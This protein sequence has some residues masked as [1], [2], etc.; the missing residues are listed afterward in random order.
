MRLQTRLVVAFPLFLAAAV[1][2]SSGNSNFPAKVSG[3]I[4]Y[5]G[6]P[7]TAGMVTFHSKNNEV[8]SSSLAPDGTYTMANLPVGEMT[9]CV[10]TESFN[11]NK[12]TPEYKGGK[13]PGQSGA[14]SVAPKK[15]STSSPVPSGAGQGGGSY[16]K[17]PAKYA[18]RSGSPLRAT[19]EKGN[20]TKDFE[21]TD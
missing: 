2:C 19:L 1:G 20:N 10:E 14:P 4:T 3:K 16:V 18:D 15:G 9:V 11:P 7:V 21:L 17:I 6:Q 8:Y 5:Q 13:G 12:K